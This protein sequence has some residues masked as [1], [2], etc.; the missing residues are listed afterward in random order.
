MIT[1]TCQR[2]REHR[3]SRRPAGELIRTSAYDVASIDSAAEARAFVELHH[4]SGTISPP[5]HRFG[6]YGASGLV[7]VAIF[8]PSPSMAA[9]RKVFPTLTIDEGQTLGRLVLLDEVPGNGESWFIARCFELLARRGVIGIESCADPQPRS[10]L[11]GS[12]THRGHVG[13]VY[14]ASNGHYVG[15]TNPSSL[16]LLPDGT[17]LSNRAC[18]K[19]ARRE[20]GCEY[21][22]G[23]LVKWGADPLHDDEDALEWLRRWR[24]ALTRPMRHQGNH[25]YLWCLNRRRRRQ[26]IT[27]LALPYPKTSEW[28]ETRRAATTDRT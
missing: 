8:G 2:W 24:T 27:G 20:Q 11:D 14:C 4:Y 6:L 18:G 25:R 28:L 23:Q 9:H 1:E 12:L 26:V 3:E 17:A 15:K 5:A 16:R 21:A 13:T 7:G 19:I 22:V 10:A